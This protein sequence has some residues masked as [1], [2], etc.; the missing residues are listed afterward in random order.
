MFKFNI[1][2][3]EVLDWFLF[4]RDLLKIKKRPIDEEIN[5]MIEKYDEIKKTRH[6]TNLFFIYISHSLGID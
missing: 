2:R 1:L 3:N 4:K 6:K 5:G